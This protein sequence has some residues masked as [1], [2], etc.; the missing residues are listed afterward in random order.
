MSNK[1][2]KQFHNS[3]DA[4]CPFGLLDRAIATFRC[5]VA[6]RRAVD[7]KLPK[8][9]WDQC[10]DPLLGRDKWSHPTLLSSG[11]FHLA[12]R[13]SIALLIACSLFLTGCN[14]QPAT[15]EVF[16]KV[17]VAGKP[18]D[19]GDI[20][21]QP[22]EGGGSTSS[23]KITNGQYRLSGES[24]LVSGAYLVKVNAYRE[25]SNKSNMIGGGLDMPP[26]TAGMTRKEQ[27]LPEKYNAKSTIEKLVVEDGK[28][29]IER[30]FELK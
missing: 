17:S 19:D 13:L 20:T 26:E 10:P 4:C 22:I 23:G 9:D 6:F 8:V 27:Y 18:I 15:S 2:L 28:T 14:S 16:G 24:G 3:F 25:P 11:V 7:W 30:D 21:F 5:P 1:P 29:K 12:A